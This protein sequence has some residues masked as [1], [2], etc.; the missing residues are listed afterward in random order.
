MIFWSFSEYRWSTIARSLPGRT[1]NEI[2]NYWRTHFKKKGKPCYQNTEK[3][4]ARLLKRQQFQ[5]QQQQKQQAEIDMQ[6]SVTL[7][8][9]N[10]TEL[11]SS[12]VESNYEL[13]QP[14]TFIDKEVLLPL[15]PFDLS[16][17]D[18]LW[19]M[20]DFHGDSS[21]NLAIYQHTMASYF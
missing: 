8:N 5:Q 18:G 14:D 12:S 16:I 11:S 20:S 17:W 1:D 3:L 6:K 7:F 9:E 13:V 4:R 19:S 15:A 2:K 10:N 21:I